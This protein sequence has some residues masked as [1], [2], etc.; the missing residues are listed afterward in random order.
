MQY[1]KPRSYALAITLFASL[2]L[3]NTVAAANPSDQ[4]SNQ[5]SQTHG[6]SVLVNPAQPQPGEPTLA[7]QLSNVENPAN[8]PAPVA[9][10]STPSVSTT[11]APPAYPWFSN[12]ETPLVSPLV[13][14]TNVLYENLLTYETQAAY[15]QSPA[16]LQGF[17]A[18][19]QTR[20]VTQPVINTDPTGQV[21][22][23]GYT[24]TSVRAA[25]FPRLKAHRLAQGYPVKAK[26][27][28]LT[29][30]LIQ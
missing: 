6:N 11:T 15:E 23:A 19:Q 27:A 24:T 3:I 8:T 2:L 12:M 9:P 5:A 17:F 1:P 20:S 21:T 26:D 25:L 16:P 18:R 4:A 14:Q 10:P 29:T 13:I 28:S 22:A 7:P 30:V